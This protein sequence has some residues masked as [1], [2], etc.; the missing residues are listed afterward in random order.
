M[1]CSARAKH[2]LHPAM[3]FSYEKF[4]SNVSIGNKRNIDVNTIDYDA[5]GKEERSSL[6]GKL[7]AKV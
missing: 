2:G 3:S 5:Y 6:P 1:L 7:T 4:K